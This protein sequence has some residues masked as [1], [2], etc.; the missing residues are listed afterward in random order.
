MGIIKAVMHAVL[1][2]QREQL[3]PVGGDQLLIRG[4][5][6]LAR[7]QRALREIV[8]VG[9][10]ADDLRDDRDVGILSD[11][12]EIVHDP[13][14]KGAVGKLSD[15]ENIFDRQRKTEAFFN[16]L[17]VF[18]QKACGAVT[19]HTEAKNCYLYHKCSLN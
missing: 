11:R 19:D 2:R 16:M 7:L 17:G 14:G 13:V 9:N 8:G 10:A 5:D 1:L 15:I 18:R 12:R 3:V 6:R 4:D